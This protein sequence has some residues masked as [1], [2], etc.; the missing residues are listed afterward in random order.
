VQACAISEVNR[1]AP[2]KGGP[3]TANKTA[4]G[5]GQARAGVSVSRPQL[6][7]AGPRLWTVSRTVDADLIWLPCSMTQRTAGEA[8]GRWRAPGVAG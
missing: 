5:A 3:A 6:T 4:R 2:I 7:A 8:C 1:A